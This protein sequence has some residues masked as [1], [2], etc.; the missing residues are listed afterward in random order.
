[1]YKLHKQI[2]GKV[3]DALLLFKRGFIVTKAVLATGGSFL[4]V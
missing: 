2:E 4:F 1:M 3:L